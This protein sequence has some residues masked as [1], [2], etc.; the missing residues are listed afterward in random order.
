MVSLGK[1]RVS[2]RLSTTLVPPEATWWGGGRC[3]QA[4]L[5]WKRWV[6]V[7]ARLCDPKVTWGSTLL[8]FSGPAS[9]SVTCKACPWATHV[10]MGTP[11]CCGR[12]GSPLQQGPSSPSG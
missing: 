4:G 12:Q 2:F 3:G 8:A 5:V 11:G 10:Q 7:C 1:A 9:F 6:L